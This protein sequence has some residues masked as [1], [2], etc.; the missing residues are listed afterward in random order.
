M[1]RI[2]VEKSEVLKTLNDISRKQTRK[3]EFYSVTVRP[4]KGQKHPAEGELF[5]IT[6]K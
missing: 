1:R 6:I 5:A 3:K 2:I 4:Y